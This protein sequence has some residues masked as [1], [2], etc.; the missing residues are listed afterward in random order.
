MFAQWVSC[1]GAF[2]IPALQNIWYY[3]RKTRK[4]HVERWHL[5]IQGHQGGPEETS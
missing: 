3:R 5:A 4:K 1:W 2:E